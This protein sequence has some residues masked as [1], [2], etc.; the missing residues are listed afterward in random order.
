MHAVPPPPSC[1]QVDTCVLLITNPISFC[2]PFQNFVVD[3][4]GI[5][6]KDLVSLIGKLM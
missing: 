4:K 6:Q 5:S 1:R 2:L 3:K